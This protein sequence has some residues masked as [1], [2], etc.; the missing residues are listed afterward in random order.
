MPQPV[1]TSTARHRHRIFPVTKTR[2]ITE[3]SNA[4]GKLAD[5][6]L[7]GRPTLISRDGKLVVLQ[8]FTPAP[9]GPPSARPA[10]YFA[11]CYGDPVEIE[12]ENRCGRA[13]DRAM[14]PWEVWTFDF[15]EEDRHPA[16]VISKP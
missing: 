11:D 8:A 16:I 15:T 1:A 14:K 10:G 13:S 12:L 3:A 4:L 5:A 6:A 7:R 2:S 9:G